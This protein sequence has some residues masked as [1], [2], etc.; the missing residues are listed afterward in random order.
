RAALQLACR[1]IE[2]GGAPSAGEVEKLLRR[3]VGGGLEA[4][5]LLA[6]VSAASGDIHTAV[7]QYLA[8]A[9]SHERNGRRR[10]AIQLLRQ[11]VKTCN[12]AERLV[13]RLR[14]LEDE[15]TSRKPSWSRQGRPS[16]GGPVGKTGKIAVAGTL[17]VACVA[18]IL[19]LS[20]VFTTSEATA[21]NEDAAE[22]SSSSGA[23]PEL[24]EIPIDGRP[25]IDVSKLFGVESAG[26]AGA[27]EE[28][29]DAN[30]A[31]RGAVAGS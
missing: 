15:A 31:E 9:E 17:L 20:G 4:D 10:D 29:D 11:A 1:L 2:L 8:I 14:T 19:H 13:E 18:V 28:D 12:G 30:D 22:S 21:A 7:E 25:G 27:E 26:G 16:R 24:A 23:D 5:S 6:A 3:L